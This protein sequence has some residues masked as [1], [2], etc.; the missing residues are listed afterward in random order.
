LGKFIFEQLLLEWILPFSLGISL[1]LLEGLVVFQI[2]QMD[3][4]GEIS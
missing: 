4:L 2:I 1:D 3:I